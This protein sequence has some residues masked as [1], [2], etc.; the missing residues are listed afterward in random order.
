MRPEFWDYELPE[1][2]IA[3][4]PASERDAARLLLVRRDLDLI[5]HR[6]FRDLPDLLSP[7]DL[8]VLNDTRVLAARLV[9]QR[10][11]TGGRWEGLFLRET[12]NGLWELLAQTRGKPEI[13]EAIAIEPGPL[14]LILRGRAEGHWLAKPEPA[15]SAPELLAKHGRVPLPPY[16]RK[17]EAMEADCERYQTVYARADGSVAAPTAGLHFTPALFDRLQQR[18][19]RTTRVTLHVGLG[20]FEP[21]KDDPGGHMMHS[22]WAKVP[23]GTVEAI[24][25]CKARGGRVIA[26]GTTATR[27]LESAA[28]EGELAAW[29]GE[30]NL[31]I[32]PPY[33]F[34]VIDGLITNFHLPKTT[35]LLL[36]SAFAGPRLLK[37]AYETAVAEGY[38]FYSYGDAMLIL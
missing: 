19:I 21:V 2:L 20:T 9:G 11:R 18:H 37:R 32:R 25:E 24:W 33:R 16:I 28:R 6:V 38:R 35:L 14:R 26:V 10:E 8:L 13:G 29:Q 3:Q 5:E 12:P 1:Y 15:G 4:E 36:V 31:Y 17:G 27:A 22:E 23:A 7:G 34:R 30:T